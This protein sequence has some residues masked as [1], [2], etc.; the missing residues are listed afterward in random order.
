MRTNEDIGKAHNRCVENV[1]IITVH[2]TVTKGIGSLDKAPTRN[3]PGANGIKV[4]GD[5]G[6][7][8]KN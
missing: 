3:T 5:P 7:S 4:I 2:G 6:T 8:K 1:T